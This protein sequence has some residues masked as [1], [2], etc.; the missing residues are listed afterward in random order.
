MNHQ[1]P[2]RVVVTVT[3]TRTYE[4]VLE[5]SDEQYDALCVRD[6]DDQLMELMDGVQPQCCISDTSI[7]LV[8]PLCPLTPV[9]DSPVEATLTLLMEGGVIQNMSADKPLRV[10]VADLDLDEDSLAEYREPADGTVV[11]GDALVTDHRPQVTREA[12]SSEVLAYRVAMKHGGAV[13]DALEK[14]GLSETELARE[15]EASAARGALHHWQ[16]MDL[17]KPAVRQ[18]LVDELL[19]VA[20]S[21]PV[22]EGLDWKDAWRE[23]EQANRASAAA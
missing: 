15:L 16:G 10:L 21:L 23:L 9:D 22:Q 11:I 3:E 5:I 19:Q 1:T 17:E 7:N 2:H 8:S 18:L 13:V 12:V 4:R 6:T 20:M 14:L